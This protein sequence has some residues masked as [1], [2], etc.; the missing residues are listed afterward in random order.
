MTTTTTE[1]RIE[2]R[3]RA[4]GILYLLLVLVG[5][6][7][8]LLGRSAMLVP[9]DAAA[10]VANI[11]EKEGL[12]RMGM[13][14]EVAIILIEVVLTA[15][16]YTITR[17]VS[18][19]LSMA[20]MLARYG[21]VIVMAVSLATGF[22]ALAAADGAGYLA[23]F[24]AAGQGSLA[25]MFLEAGEY[26]ITAWGFLFGIHLVLL[27]H[28]VR[29]SG[30]FPAVLGVLLMVAGAGYLLES[31]GAILWTGGESIL[32]TVVIVLAIPG[33]LGFPLW[34]LIKRLDGSAWKTRALEAAAEPAA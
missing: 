34:L 32:A 19:S 8:L 28:L 4:A 16:L 13:T 25:A 11:V 6:F 9:D 24:D 21:M 27:G 30:F 29:R 23:G 15:L 22:L 1:E 33:E 12:F 5:P 31:F 18:R 17:P 2:R 26:L 7:A 3:A 10:T 14:A 20:A